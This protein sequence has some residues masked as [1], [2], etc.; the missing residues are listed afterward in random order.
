MTAK[1]LEDKAPFTVCLQDETIPYSV[2]MDNKTVLITPK[3]DSA[4][5]DDGAEGS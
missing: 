5:E 4:P 3:D 1:M 2:R